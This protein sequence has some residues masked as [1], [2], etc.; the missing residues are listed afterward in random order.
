MSFHKDLLDL[1]ETG[2]TIYGMSQLGKGPT[3]SAGQTTE[4]AFQAYRDYYP[5]KTEEELAAGADPGYAQIMR[6]EQAQDLA[7]QLQLTHQSSR[8]QK[9]VEQVHALAEIP[10]QIFRAVQLT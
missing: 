9:V 5:T 1:A 3:P 4:Q 6:S 2:A 8:A 7:H 10:Y